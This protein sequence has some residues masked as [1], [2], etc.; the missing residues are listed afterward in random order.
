M[1]QTAEV[2]ALCKGR[3][4]K[5]HVIM[6]PGTIPIVMNL[7]PSTVVKDVILEVSRQLERHNPLETEEYALFHKEGPKEQLL[8]NEDYL[9]DLPLE[10]GS[11]EDSHLLFKRLTW[12]LPSRGYVTRFFI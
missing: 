8:R 3:M 2:E 9:F 7:K 12:I 4:T 5:R 10:A 6:L 11:R 1:P